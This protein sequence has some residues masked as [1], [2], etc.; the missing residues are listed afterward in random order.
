MARML[1]MAAVKDGRLHRHRTEYQMQT[2]RTV[3]ATILLILLGLVLAGCAPV[4]TQPQRADPDIARAQALM[5]QQ[6]YA[7]A[8]QLYESL[9]QR[10][11]GAEGSAFLLEAIEA[12]LRAD[13][14]DNAQRLLELANARPLSDRQQ[15]RLALLRAELALARNQAD[16]ALEVLLDMLRPDMPLDLK[17]RHLRDLA[18]AYRRLGNLLESAN[19]LQQLDALL[20]DPEERL[21]VQTEILRALSALNERTLETLRPS[22]PGIAGGWMDLALLIKRYA[23][24]PQELAARVMQWRATHP[25]HPALP[26]LIDRFVAQLEGQIERAEHIAVLLPEA[27]R[28][29]GA[30]DAIRDGLMISLYELPEA[31]RPLLRFYDTSDPATAWPVYAQAV[32]AGAQAVI[33]P[34]Q[35]DSVRQLL[36][37]G[38]LPVPVLALNKVTGDA[39]A[40]RNLFMFSLDPEHEAR[41]AA[42]R[43]WQQGLRHPVVLV[44][45]DTLGERLEQAFLDR[46][47]TLTGDRVDSQRYDP[48]SADHSAPI[49]ALLHID[50]SK[51]RHARLQRWLG[52][53]IEFEPRRRADVDVVFMVATPRQ[54]Q[55]IKPQLAFFRAADLPT[56]ATSMAWNGHLTAQQLADMRGIRL[57][58]I[59]LIVNQEERK[60][61]GRTIPGV[62]GPGVRLY[63]LG[64]DALR[65]QPNL[66]RLL[67]NPW[68]SVDGQTGNLYVNAERRIERQLVWIELDDP[69][70]LLGY[71]NRMDLGGNGAPEEQA[72][73]GSDLPPESAPDGESQ[74]SQGQ[75]DAAASSREP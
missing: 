65:L 19:T 56:Y 13:D 75:A 57:P 20:Q 22:P 29:A 53:R 12:A 37:A 72:P 17:K 54:A 66:R 25:D 24:E 14:L 59:P 21:Q 64:T 26:Q 9:A 44:P 34:L 27:G 41:L 36:H 33:G 45:E 50:R 6:D 74:A 46:W 18:K 35:K 42:E 49:S 4:P 67:E 10:R 3:V 58:D 1:P 63:A 70:Q 7:A 47:L 39:G 8:S 15:L 69:P 31:Q 51:A 38:D 68:E 55:S 61:L 30:A 71:S 16:R 48:D 52:Q 43:I 11:P 62:L 2:N 40:P 28:Y 5:Q 23:T 60:R 73:T 32:A